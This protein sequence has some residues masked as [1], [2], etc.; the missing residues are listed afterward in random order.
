MDYYDV[1]AVSN[2]SLNYID[3]ASRDGTPEQ[4]R[5][6]LEGRISFSTSSTDLGGWFHAKVLEPERFIYAGERSLGH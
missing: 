1:R 6:F 2:T 3:P 4:F 5:A